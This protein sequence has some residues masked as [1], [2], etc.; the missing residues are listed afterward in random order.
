M[1]DHDYYPLSLWSLFLVF[2]VFLPLFIVIG[3]AAGTR[4]FFK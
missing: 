2:L 3:V 4:W 1:Y